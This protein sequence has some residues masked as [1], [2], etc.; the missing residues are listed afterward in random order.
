[1]KE[2]LV[3]I[4]EAMTK[5]VIVKIPDNTSLEAFYEDITDD[6]NLGRN[7]MNI[8]DTDSCAFTLDWNVL[9]TNPT[10]NDKKYLQ[11][12]EYGKG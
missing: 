1:M 2:Y 4:T 11:T 8:K 10:E 12:I 3:N 7:G 5:T 9:P 6:V